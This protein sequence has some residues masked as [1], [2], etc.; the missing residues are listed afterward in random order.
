MHRG[1]PYPRHPTYW[2]TEAWFWPGFVPWKLVMY[3]GSFVDA[4]WDLIP[5]FWTGISDPGYHDSKPLVIAYDFFVAAGTPPVRFR[6]LLD[7]IGTP[8][9]FQ[10]RWRG[11]LC[12][13]IGFPL[14]TAFAVQP[15][16]QT[17]VELVSFDYS[18]PEPPYTYTD[19][20]LISLAPAN[21]AEGGSPYD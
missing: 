19:G 11:E 18:E 8:G 12:H 16:P 21:Y 15:Y 3:A 4:P 10:A 1:R 6:V 13:I 2:A 17:V 14:S 5:P 7:R 20:P 9:N